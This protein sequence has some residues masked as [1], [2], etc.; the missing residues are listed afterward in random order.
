M[1]KP[2][3]EEF[4]KRKDLLIDC[5]ENENIS[6]G[7]FVKMARTS[8]GRTQ[9]EYA[10]AMK[11]EVKTLSLIEND[12]ANITMKTAEKLLKPWGMQLTVKKK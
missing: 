11:L 5:I 4:Q 6:F 7:Q 1:K 8:T 3:Q 12:K 10:D 9:K 2:K